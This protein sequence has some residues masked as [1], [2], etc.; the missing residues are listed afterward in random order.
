M[1]HAGGKERKRSEAHKRLD[2]DIKRG[3][4]VCSSCGVEKRF[5]FDHQRVEGKKMFV[6]DLD[7][8]WVGARCSEC[9]PAGKKKGTGRWPHS[10]KE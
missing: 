3:R 2:F 4:R 1:R 8:L 6:D 5:S 9:G 7:K 10:E